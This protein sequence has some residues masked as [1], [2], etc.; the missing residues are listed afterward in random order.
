MNTLEIL[1]SFKAEMKL[2][3]RGLVFYLP[4]DRI[5][6][7]MFVELAADNI[8]TSLAKMNL[9][10]A[11]IHYKDMKRPIKLCAEMAN[12]S[13]LA[14]KI[15]MQPIITSIPGIQIAKVKLSIPILRVLQNF[16]EYPENRCALVRVCDERQVALTESSA[17]LLTKVTLEEAVRRKRKEYWYLP[18]LAEFKRESSQKLEPNNEA[19]Y[20]EFSWRG[21]SKDGLNWR[22]FTTKYKLVEDAY[23]VMY[24]V[25]QNLGV[26][27]I[28]T[29]LSISR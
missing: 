14:K 19:S 17:I 20:I 5:D 12:S 9:P 10:F 28:S 23:G 6:A 18:D 3:S 29:P 25:T 1:K 7:E 13:K 26:E 22:R 15:M 16:C 4:G 21:V 27:Q 24:H 11:Y 2:A 8:V